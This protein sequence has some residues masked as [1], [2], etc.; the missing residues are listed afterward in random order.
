MLHQ[1]DMCLEWQRTWDRENKNPQQVARDKV[2]SRGAEGT[3]QPIFLLILRLLLPSPLVTSDGG[4]WG[5]EYQALSK[6]QSL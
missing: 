4:P 2:Q 6:L 1:I 5:S 3:G